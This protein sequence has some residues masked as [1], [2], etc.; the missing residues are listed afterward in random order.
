MYHIIERSTTV[1][2]HRQ[3]T[4][5]GFKKFVKQSAR[6]PYCLESSTQRF[7]GDDA[8]MMKIL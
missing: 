6:K 5:C 2:R 3:R 4:I 8:V 7:F 1:E